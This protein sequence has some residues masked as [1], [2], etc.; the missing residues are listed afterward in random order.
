MVCVCACVFM[1]VCARLCASV[2][3]CVCLCV[4]VRVCGRGH[5]KKRNRSEEISFT[6]E[7]VL[8]RKNESEIPMKRSVEIHLCPPSLVDKF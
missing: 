5:Y 8:S 2:F 1:R 7:N 6:F 4:R 3:V